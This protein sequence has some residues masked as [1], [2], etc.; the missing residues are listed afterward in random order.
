MYYVYIAT[1]GLMARLPFSILYAISDGISFLLFRVFKYRRAIV[2]QQ[3]KECFPEWSSQKVQ[4]VARESS[5]NLADIMVESFKTDILSKSEMMRRYNVLNP[6]R[7]NEIANGGSNLL[8]LGAHFNNWEWG[9]VG[10]NHFFD[11]QVYGLYKPVGNAL[12]NEHVTKAREKVG[13]KMVPIKE[14][15][16]LFE[17]ELTPSSSVVFVADQSPSNMVDAVWIDFLGRET[18][19]LHGVEKYAK[20]TGWPVFFWQVHRVSR[21]FY[22]VEVIELDHTKP[23]NLIQEYMSILEK[24]I[25]KCPSSWLWTHRRWKRRKEEA[26]TQ[27]EKRKLRSIS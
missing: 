20:L 16:S 26:Q 27:L 8:V 9:S 2:E 3:L 7:F 25:I 18:A 5:R 4:E 11:S 13:T 14:T 10:V 12:I 21:G 17:K 1:V 22:E 24:D 19:C 15:R 23:E 6:E